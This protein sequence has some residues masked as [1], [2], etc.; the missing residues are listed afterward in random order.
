MLKYL[1]WY[2]QNELAYSR[3]QLDRRMNEMNDD[4]GRELDELKTKLMKENHFLKSLA[5]DQSHKT[6]FAPIYEFS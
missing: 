1:T 6:F 3:P 2:S 5:R 4:R